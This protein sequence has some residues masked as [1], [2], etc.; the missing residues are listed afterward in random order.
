[1]N[2]QIEPRSVVVA[3]D[4]SEHAERALH[5]AA[6]QAA[7]EHRPLAVVAVGDDAGAI[8]EEGVT[9]ARRLHPRPGAT[10]P[11]PARRPRARCSSTCRSGPASS[12]SAPGGEARSRACC[13]AR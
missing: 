2:E 13:S 12:S 1:M 7:L 3:V 6:E 11:R 10:G 4:G 9:A 8:A 5:W